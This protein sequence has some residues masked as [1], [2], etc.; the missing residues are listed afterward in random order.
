[1]KL[2]ISDY[3]DKKINNLTVVRKDTSNE[4]PNFN[5]WIFRCEC[6]KEFS[7]VPSR[8]ISGH[9][10]SCGCKKGKASL[11]HG[12]NGDEFYPTW[13]GMM[14]RCYH[15]ENHNYQRYGGRGIT[16]CEEWHDPKAFIDWARKTVGHKSPGLTL[17]RGDNSK[18]YSPENCHWATPKEQARNRRSNRVLTI[19][20]TSKPFVEWC[21]EYGIDPSVVRERIKLGWSEEDALS[22][23]IQERYW[24]Y[25][26]ERFTAPVK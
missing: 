6:G 8:V 23:P 26:G 7:S 25:T 24:K 3:I 1:M 4:H 12:C 11:T 10:K 17:E 9:I 2:D 16:V 22:I 13:W 14:R 18:G 5:R 19:D 20:G 15:K 21:E